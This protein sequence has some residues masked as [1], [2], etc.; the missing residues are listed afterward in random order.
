M[1]HHDIAGGNDIAK[2]NAITAGSIINA[3]N[4]LTC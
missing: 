1:N 3:I 2:A 4:K